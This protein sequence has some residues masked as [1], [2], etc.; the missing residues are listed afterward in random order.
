RHVRRGRA[1]AVPP[2]ADRRRAHRPGRQGDAHHRQVGTDRPLADLLRTR[3]GGPH[4]LSTA[5]Y[6]RPLRGMGKKQVRQVR[7]QM[8]KVQPK[9]AASNAQGA[10]RK[11]RER[12]VQSGGMLQG[13]AP[14]YVVR[15]EYISVAVAVVCLL[16]VAA[17][18]IFL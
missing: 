3:R 12:Y 6:T 11:Q 18:L 2:L 1:L 5:G 7:Q 8:R 4:H 10:T 9:Q 17:L 16:I 15:I 14:E 13:Y